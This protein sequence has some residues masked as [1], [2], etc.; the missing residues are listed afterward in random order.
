MTSGGVMGDGVGLGLAD[1]LGVGV[2][3]GIVEG[4]GE[5]LGVG[6]GVGVGIVEGLGDGVGVGVG[7]GVGFGVGVGLVTFTIV[8]PDRTPR[9]NATISAVPE[10]TAFAVPLE[11][12]V[13]TASLFED[14]LKI[15]SLSSSPAESRAFAVNCSCDPRKTL[16]VGGE[17]TT[18]LT[19]GEGLNGLPSTVVPGLNGSMFEAS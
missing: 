19:P 12:I 9:A 4:L 8:A 7:V 18:K 13:T 6:V 17:T 1:G 3:V 11:L 2:G 14:Q 10:P 15:T 16:A 5:G